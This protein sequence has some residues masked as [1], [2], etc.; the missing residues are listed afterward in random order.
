[1]TMTEKEIFTQLKSLKSITLSQEVKDANREVLLSQI[2]NTFIKS[3][4]SVN[5]FSN[6]KNIIS[7]IYKPALTVAGVFVFLVGVLFLSSGLFSKTKPNNSFYIAR[8]LS[9]KARLN[10]TF[11]ED[12][13]DALSLQF[14]SDHAQDIATVLMDPEFNTEENKDEVN[15]LN[16]SFENEIAKVQNQINKN[17]EVPT[18]EDVAV[19]SSGLVEENGTDIYIN[20]ENVSNDN[21][22]LA[23]SSD[24]DLNVYAL[25]EEINDSSDNLVNVENGQKM[26]DEIKVL[27]TEGK[28]SEVVEKL[29]ELKKMTNQK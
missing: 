10:T 19:S 17:V 12:Q 16:A 8:I 4:T 7:F 18:S 21:S 22:D 29:N 14:A 26:L 5:G 28:Y 20:G 13:R 2:S 1:M 23:T 25:A 27:F 3:E 6:I 9:E 11:N 15:K 24:T